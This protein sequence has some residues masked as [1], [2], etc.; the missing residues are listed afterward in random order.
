VNA[1]P[2]VKVFKNALMD[3]ISNHFRPKCTIDCRIF[4]IKSR[5]FSG[6]ITGPPQKRPPPLLGHRHQFPLGSPAFQLFRF[7]ENANAVASLCYADERRRDVDVIVDR[8]ALR[9]PTPAVSRQGL[10]KVGSEGDDLTPN[11]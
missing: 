8:S 4:H 2:I 10:E 11:L 9:Y 6:V 1:V 7:Y 3:G 5:N